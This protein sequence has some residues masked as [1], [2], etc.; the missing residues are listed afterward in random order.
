[1]NVGGSTGS[2]GSVGKI[3]QCRQ[4]DHPGTFDNDVGLIKDV[5]GSESEVRKTDLALNNHLEVVDKNRWMFEN[6]FNDGIKSSTGASVHGLNTNM[7][8]IAQVYIEMKRESAVVLNGGSHTWTIRSIRG[9]GE[10]GWRGNGT[11]VRVT[12]F[13]VKSGSMCEIGWRRTT[14]DWRR[15]RAANDWRRNVVRSQQRLKRSTQFRRIRDGC[16]SGRGC[17][18]NL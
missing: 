14:D 4:W 15:R 12:K 8:I 17:R 3:W 13:V 1:V 5:K 10:I 18:L 2:V 16:L 7:G 11:R 9:R 6:V